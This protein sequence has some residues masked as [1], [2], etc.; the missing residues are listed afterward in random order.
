MKFSR[1]L[2]QFIF[3]IAISGCND[4]NAYIREAAEIPGSCEATNVPYGTPIVKITFVIH[5]NGNITNKFVSQ[6]S[7]YKVIDDIALK[8]IDTCKYSLLLM[9][10][11][12]KTSIVERTYTWS[13]NIIK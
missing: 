7:G 10:M 8:N 2:A 6:S 12:N 1:Y 11:K 5:E 3:F 4:K 9:N 13:E